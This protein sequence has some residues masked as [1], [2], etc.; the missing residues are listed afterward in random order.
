MYFINL[1]GNHEIKIHPLHG[2][3]ELENNLKTLNSYLDATKLKIKTVNLLPEIHVKD[4]D[5]KNKQYPKDFKL[6][7]DSKNADAYLTLNNNKKIVVDFKYITGNGGHITTH[8]NEAS[9]KAEY[10]I[11][12]LNENSNM[13]DASLIKIAKNRTKTNDLKGI[14]IIDKNDKII[15]DTYT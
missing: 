2:K 15:I 9:Q 10:V 5:L 11:I 6:R 13:S 7:I 12:K 4:K 14:C 1:Y 3:E 8:I